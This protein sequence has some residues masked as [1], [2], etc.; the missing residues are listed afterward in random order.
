MPDGERDH[1]ER[2]QQPQ[3][4]RV[5]DQLVG[6]GG[7]LADLAHDG[8]E[9]AD[10]GE[11]AEQLHVHQGE[12]VAAVVVRAEVAGEHR[13]RDDAERQHRS[14]A[15]QLDGRVRRDSPPSRGRRAPGRPG[16]ARPLETP[17][18]RAVRSA[19]SWARS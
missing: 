3:G 7:V 4:E 10:V 5:A 19:R 18:P 11:H 8:R 14:L 1:H 2:Q 17:R 15:D 16:H 6:A 12:R 13:D 9:Q